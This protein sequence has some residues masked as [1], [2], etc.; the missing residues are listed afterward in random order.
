MLPS[1]SFA[2]EF[3]SSFS[4]R[5]VSS[6]SSV[7]A[8]F[9][10]S[11]NAIDIVRRIRTE[12]NGSGEPVTTLTCIIIT[13]LS[14]QRR[15]QKRDA[16]ATGNVRC[17]VFRIYIVRSCTLTS[18]L[19]SLYMIYGRHS[20]CQRRHHKS[21]KCLLEHMWWIPCLTPALKSVSFLV[22]LEIWIVRACVRY[23]AGVYMLTD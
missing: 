21:P 10:C 14:Q 5:L 3:E 18:I 8:S 19:Y 4:S 13:A 11:L 1:S 22:R 9:L 2:S 20:R 12:H 23:I 16:P 15:Q 17:G 6:A 7:C